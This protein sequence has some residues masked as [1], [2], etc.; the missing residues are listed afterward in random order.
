MDSWNDDDGDR[1]EL[2]I[3]F[4]RFHREIPVDLGSRPGRQ[5]LNLNFHDVPQLSCDIR[6][7]LHLP[8]DALIA[9]QAEKNAGC[10]NTIAFEKPLNGF[11]AVIVPK[12]HKPLE[13]VCTDE[14]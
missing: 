1:H 6:W 11:F 9:R 3:F 13:P 4:W 8:N 2:L 10:G 14:P 5:R 7:K 12:G